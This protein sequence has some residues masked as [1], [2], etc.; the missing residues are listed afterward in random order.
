MAEDAR[1]AVERVTLDAQAQR[2]QSESYRLMLDQNAS[3]EVLRRKNQSRLPLVYESRNLF[4]TPRAGAGRS[5][6]GRAGGAG[7]GL[8]GAECDCSL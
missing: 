8:S 6:G 3:N 4:N 7:A 1:M 5:G 2:I